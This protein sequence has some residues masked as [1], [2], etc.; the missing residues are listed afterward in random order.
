MTF[1]SLSS[2]IVC[3]QHRLDLLCDYQIKQMWLL[4]QTEKIMISDYYLLWSDDSPSFVLSVILIQLVAVKIFNKQVIYAAFLKFPPETFL[5]IDYESTFGQHFPCH[6][7]IWQSYNR[8]FTKM[9]AEV[10]K[11][12][13]NWV[14][15]W[16]ADW[17]YVIQA[18]RDFCFPQ[19]WECIRNVF[20]CLNI[21]HWMNN[22]AI[23]GK[24]DK[25][26]HLD[27]TQ[28]CHL[29]MSWCQQYIE[30]LYLWK[31]ER[32]SKSLRQSISVTH[33]V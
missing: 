5:S 31:T 23:F 17:Q 13:D 1:S 3:F 12:K 6:K 2:F 11:E 22:S 8:F 25:C 15:L 30:M 27:F 7:I 10:D 14:S 24:R 18:Y 29:K 21:M 33:T 20:F 32:K 16:D 19:Q 26:T 4:G 28:N 9:I